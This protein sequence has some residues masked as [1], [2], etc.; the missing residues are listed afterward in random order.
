MKLPP[1]ITQSQR[2]FD[3]NLPAKGLKDI[4]YF[5]FVYPHR[6]PVADEL[7]AFTSGV[8]TK[9]KSL[10]M[11]LMSVKCHKLKSQDAG[12]HYRYMPTP[13]VNAGSSLATGAR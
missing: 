10:S 3:L 6:A 8:G 7:P 11:G 4:T 9:R 1:F 13:D 5:I 12:V 2:W